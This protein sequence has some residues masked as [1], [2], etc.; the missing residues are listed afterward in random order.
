MEGQKAIGDCDEYKGIVHGS[1]D[2]TCGAISFYRL[3]N[4]PLRGA[5][6]N[7]GGCKWCCE[8][9]SRRGDPYKAEGVH[10][11]LL[12]SKHSSST[13]E[14]KEGIRRNHNCCNYAESD[15]QSITVIDVIDT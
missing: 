6:V 12:L 3:F 11:D 5:D 4:A 14:E 15:D 7:S 2:D 10:H 13:E 8:S 1:S 9:T